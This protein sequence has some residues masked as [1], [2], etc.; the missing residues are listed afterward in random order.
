MV[1]PS[2]L[3]M[4]TCAWPAGSA[5]RGLA[6]EVEQQRTLGLQRLVHRDQPVLLLEG[7]VLVL[8]G[9]RDLHPG[10]VRRPLGQRRAVEAARVVVASVGWAP[11]TY[12][13]ALLRPGRAEEGVELRAARRTSAEPGP[14]ASGWA[15][16]GP[17]PPRLRSRPG[18][19]P[20]HDRGI[21]R[22][23]ELSI[24]GR[25]VRPS[26]S[27]SARS[28]SVPRASSA[29]RRSGRR[30][31]CRPC[32]GRCAGR[33]SVRSERPSASVSCDA[34]ADVLGEAV[35]ADD[36]G[37]AGDVAGV[38]AGGELGSVGDA[39]AVGVGGERVGVADGGLVAVGEAVGVGVGLV[40][41]VPA[42]LSN[43]SVSPSWSRSPSTGLVGRRPGRHPARR[44][45]R[46]RRPAG[47]RSCRRSCR[48]HGGLRSER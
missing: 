39:V 12:G 47:A 43:S 20:R 46:H 29:A 42:S 21:Q 41:S 7:H 35:R 4:A 22:V 16:G 10:L 23:G 19:A 17:G 3:L 27:V 18:R 25:S 15:C 31:R 11:Y 1:W 45:L 28:G 40:G 14:A 5:R 37:G 38:G 32:R 44:P 26:P 8:R 33:I 2:P 48:A 36:A 24:S 6:G 30:R 13:V 9:A 34:V